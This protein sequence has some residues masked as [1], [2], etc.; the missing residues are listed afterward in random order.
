MA[1]HLMR[2]SLQPSALPRTI[3]QVIE[4]LDAI[5]EDAVAAQ[6]R[7]GYFAAL[8]NRVTMA[9]RD[10]IREHAFQDNSRMERLDVAFANR[11]IDAYDQYHRGERPRTSWLLVFDATGRRDL[12][13]LQHLV[14]GMNAHINL[15]LGIAC[16]EIAPGNAIDALETDFTR[17]NDVLATLLPMVEAHL[18]EISH[19][20][21]TLTEVAHDLNGLDDRVGMFSMVEARRGAWRLARR[22]AHINNPLAREVA[23]AARDTG[24]ALLGQELQR[25]GP[26]SELLG[27]A[28]DDEVN[29]ASYIRVLA[30]GGSG[31]TGT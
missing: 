18:G 10:G 16:A 27:G 1:H 30:R 14:L 17:I 21:G 28:D 31:V 9:V 13:V 4:R 11:Y 6:S 7:V 26:A 5:V 24:T 23:I 25:P 8:Y 15:D 22:L 2:P 19:R 12:S 29:V 20:L 3:D